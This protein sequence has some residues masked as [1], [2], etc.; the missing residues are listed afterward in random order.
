MKKVVDNSTH[1][2]NKK[3]GDKLKLFIGDKEGFGGVEKVDVK[4]VATEINKT[5]GAV[6][7][8]LN[9]TNSISLYSFLKIAKFIGDPAFINAVLSLIGYTGAHKMEADTDLTWDQINKSL[10]ILLLNN[11]EAKENLDSQKKALTR[12]R[13]EATITMLQ[14]FLTKFQG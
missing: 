13:I 5:E 8:Y 6:Y 11:F 14:A 12:I 1:N 4:D 9:G 3:I 7:S 10:T 2:G